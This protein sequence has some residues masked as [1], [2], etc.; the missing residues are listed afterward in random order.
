MIRRWKQESFAALGNR[1]FRILW[2]GS[3]FLMLAF[4]MAFTVQ[5]VVAF[6]LEGSNGAVGVVNTGLGISLL[7]LGPYGGVIADRVS[8][9]RLLVV[10]Q[11]A[12]GLVMLAVGVLIVTDSVT[13]VWL[14]LGTLVM[15]VAFSFAGPA[16]QA[17]VGT[18][19]SGRLL[20]NAVALTQLGMNIGRVIAPLLAGVMLGT[21][22]F[23]AGG[24]YVFMAA[25]VGLALFSLGLLPPSAGTPPA[26]RRSVR[27][28]LKA[29]VDHVR[30]N[31]RLRLLMLMFMA[32][33]VL[34]FTFQIILPALLERHLDRDATDIGLIL[35][36][37]AAAGL[38]VSLALAGMVS[39]RWALPIML[40]MGA[41]MGL[42][43]FL[44]AAAPSFELALLTVLAL[45]A[46]LSGFML[47]SMALVMANTAPAYY[48]RVQSLMMLAFALQGVLGI[49]WGIL[50]DE[51][52][53][54]QM[55]VVVGVLTMA[56]VAF[57]SA[58]FAALSRGRPAAA[59]VPASPPSG[60]A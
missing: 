21:S 20:P 53:E 36:V 57:G 41:L 27:S 11:G 46:G 59:P 39:S 16:R 15:G 14:T 24:T 45:G 7:L 17:Y 60:D 13:I 1:D 4:M 54:R 34:G 8:K 55:L 43:F 29:G 48:G 6:E 12:V 23:G 33:V 26:R 32:I 10:G 3:V 47:V 50:A 56:A 58:A 31:P 52:G 37:N 44:L 51:I 49:G 35:T 30:D 28:E 38:V 9:R 19:V 40:S 42:G 5:S 22:L 2:G 25:I 18:L